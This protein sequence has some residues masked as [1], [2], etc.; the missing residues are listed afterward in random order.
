MGL[1][2]LRQNIS[3]IPQTPF[4]F[5]GSIRKNLDPFETRSEQELWA[6]LAGANL[7][8]AVERLPERLLTD[9]TNIA[10][11]FSVGQKQLLCLARALLRRNKVLVLDEATANVDMIT[12]NFIQKCI[13]TE[14]VNTT[15]VTIAHR[16]NTIAD[17]DKVIVMDKGRIVECGSPYELLQKN[18]LF[19][20]MVEHTGINAQTIKKIAKETFEG[21]K[22]F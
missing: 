15:V 13:Q 6:A 21:K 7:K 1:H 17:Y 14:F 12:D 2:S 10:E 3:V 8:E 4:L 11:V 22:K 20:E 19:A 18:G 5:K 9:V 16:L